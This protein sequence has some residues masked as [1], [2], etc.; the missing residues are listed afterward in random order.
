[1]FQDLRENV[2]V[3]KSNTSEVWERLKMDE[4]R[5]SKLESSVNRLDKNIDDKVEMIQE[6]LWTCLHGQCRMFP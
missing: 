4:Q 3:L 5:F 2:N 1:M 6:C